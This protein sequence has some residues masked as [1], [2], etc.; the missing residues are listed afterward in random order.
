MTIMI[1]EIFEDCDTAEECL[2]F[3]DHIKNYY[4][5]FNVFKNRKRDEIKRIKEIKLYAGKD[6]N[7][8]VDFQMKPTCEVIGG[9]DITYETTSGELI[10]DGLIDLACRNDNLPPMVLELR[11]NECNVY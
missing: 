1:K 9:I 2:S 11:D 8:K 4:Q 6:L 10:V 3:R 7:K 5:T